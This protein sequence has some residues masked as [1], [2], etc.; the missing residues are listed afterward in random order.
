M[1]G[2]G[3]QGDPTEIAEGLEALRADIDEAMA[4]LD[5]GEEIAGTLPGRDG[6]L[7]VNHRFSRR[8]LELKR[9]WLDEVQRELRR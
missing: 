2:P 9:E 4:M 1:D 8:M 3:A 5:R 7:R 6:V